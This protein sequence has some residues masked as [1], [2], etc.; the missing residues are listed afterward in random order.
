MFQGLSN[1]HA[2]ACENPDSLLLRR[3]CSGPVEFS[4]HKIIGKLAAF[5]LQTVGDLHLTEGFS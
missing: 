2:I 4:P 1:G 3:R 5:F